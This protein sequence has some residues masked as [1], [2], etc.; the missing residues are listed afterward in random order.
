[1]RD[2]RNPAA[3]AI[4]FLAL[5]GAATPAPAAESYDNCAGFIDAL[6]MVISTQGTWCL[7]KDLATAASS[8]NAIEIQSSNVTIDCNGFKIGGI[9]G[10][11]STTAVGIFATG[12]R[13]LAIRHCTIRGFQVGIELTGGSGYLI[14]DNLLDL[15]RFIGIEPQG[16]GSITRRNVITD[17]G[18]SPASGQ[19]Y[20]I[21]GDGD[22]LDNVIDGVAGAA[23]LTN[24]SANGIY[25]QAGN[26]GVTIQGNRVRNL[27]PKGT[28]EAIG[29]TSL[30][31]GV[32]VRDNAIA[33]PTSTVGFGVSCTD[34]T[35]HVR[36][37]VILHFGTGI[38]VACDDAGGNSIN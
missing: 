35:T 9:G 5:A 32:M 26:I 27:T 15:N 6:P 3:F 2:L 19:A 14:E 38:A 29:I 7:R 33:E 4:V 18:G 1:M 24:F 36:D 34:S 13:S 10:G 17:T 30:G 11:V 28:G 31:A 8:G 25:L 22:I 23:S 21:I 20:A 16:D 12:L 37:N